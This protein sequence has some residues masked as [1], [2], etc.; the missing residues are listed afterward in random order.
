M[1][2]IQ[3]RIYL[4]PER[5]EV[6]INL[7]RKDEG[8]VTVVATIDTGAQVSLLPES[9]L[10]M[11]DYR[12]TDEG[13]FTIEQAGI[14]QQT[15]HAVEAYIPLF[16]EDEFGARTEQF[17]AKVWF[18]DTVKYLVGF[19]GILNRAVLHLDMPNLRGYLDIG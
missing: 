10:P 8:H 6:F 7:K 18:T 5:A 13:E 11:L 19:G 17:E 12:L 2:R 14:A 16:L 3:L 4:D 9:L 15:F 1:T